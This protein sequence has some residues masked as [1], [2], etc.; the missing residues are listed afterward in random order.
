MSDVKYK[1]SKSSIAKRYG[2]HARV[3]RYDYKVIWCSELI[4][5]GRDVRGLHDH[6]THT[7]YVMDDSDALSTFIHELMHAEIEAAGMRQ[8]P[9][10][11]INLE[12]LVVELAA[13]LIATSYD[14]RRRRRRSA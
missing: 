7:I 1:P 13:R 10:W 6:T 12:E 11:N 4:Y 2:T 3:S 9:D 8:M 14:L 5:E